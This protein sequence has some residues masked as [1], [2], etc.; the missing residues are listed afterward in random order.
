MKIA[1]A[2]ISCALGDLDANVRKLRDWAARAK[3]SGADLVVFPE[4]VDTGYSM[5]VIQKHAR[6]WNEGAPPHLQKIAMEVSIGLIVGISDRDGESIFNA[7]LFVNRDGQGRNT[8][9]R[10]S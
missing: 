10:T 2:Q 3:D 7:Q 9:K 8:G 6:P 4:M 5:P 1:A